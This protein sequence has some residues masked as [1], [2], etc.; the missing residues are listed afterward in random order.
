MARYRDSFTFTLQALNF[1]TPTEIVLLLG[2]RMNW[3]LLRKGEK[4]KQE[5]IFC[6]FI[7]ILFTDTVKKVVVRSKY[8]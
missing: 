2:K 5:E 4:E 1:I 8:L 6:L 7:C 3:N